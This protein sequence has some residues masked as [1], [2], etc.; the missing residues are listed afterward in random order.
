MGMEAS[1]SYS[2]PRGTLWAN[3]WNGPTTEPVAEAQGNPGSGCCNLRSHPSYSQQRNEKSGVN[4]LPT[5]ASKLWDQEHSAGV[6]S[7]TLKFKHPRIQ[8]SLQVYRH[9]LWRGVWETEPSQRPVM[10]WCCTH[11]EVLNSKEAVETWGLTWQIMEVE[12]ISA[13]G[14]KKKWHTHYISKG[15]WIMSCF[16]FK[17]MNLFCQLAG[18]KNLARILDTNPLGHAAMHTDYWAL[19]TI[20]MAI[21]N[22]LHLTIPLESCLCVTLKTVSFKLSK[23]F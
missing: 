9:H 13:I 15:E 7:L 23:Y 4:E 12:K 6:G 19:V 14:R 8:G 5:S 21:T 11:T 22:L 2:P 18:K 3:L 17:V 10:S 16:I 1:S 20:S